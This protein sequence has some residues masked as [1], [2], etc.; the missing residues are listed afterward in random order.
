MPI[1]ILFLLV[2]SILINFAQDD[3]KTKESFLEAES[4]FLYEEYTE[5]LPVYLKLLKANPENDNLN[6]KIGVCYLNIPYEKDNAI[7][8]LEKAVKNINPSYKTNS[9]KETSAPLEALFYL[10]TAYRVNNELDKA[11]KVYKE[12]KNKVDPAVYDEDLINDQIKAIDRAKTS[13]K[14]PVF[15]EKKNLGDIVNSRFSESN[16]V[17]TFDEKVL[18][19]SVKLQFYDALFVSRKDENGE[20]GAPVNIIPELGVDGDVYPTSLSSNGN[21]MFIYRS[22]GFDGNIYETE[23]VTDKW[24]PIKK[25]NDNIN[26]KYWESHAS[27]SA[28]GKTLYFTSNRKGGYGG[29][30]IY[31][32]TRTEKYDWANV[33]NMGPEI[34][35]SYNEET[36]FITEDG[37]TLYF[38]SYGHATIGGY[39]VFYSTLQPTGE[40]SS[41][42]NMGFPINTTD[43]DIF[44]EPAQNGNFAYVTRYFP[45]NYGKNDIYRLE[46][47][48]DQHP[49]KFKLKGVIQF[50]R[51]P[52]VQSDL[53]LIMAK[54]VNLKTKD[55]I[56]RFTINPL[57]KKFLSS[58]T[59]GDYKIILE[60]EGFK[61]WV[62]EF[63]VN[64]NQPSW[65]VNLTAEML[66]SMQIA[67]PKP[68][69]AKM[70]TPLPILFNRSFFKINVGEPANIV[71]P[72][73]KGS[74]ISIQIYHDNMIVKTEDT[75][76]S[77]N[78][79]SYQFVPLEG[80]TRLV[81]K[82]T[83]LSGA[84]SIGE[85][86]IMALPVAENKMSDEQL[87][88][89][90][91]LKAAMAL[92]A[93][94]E[95]QT[96]L[97]TLDLQK[98]K[99]SSIE[100][101]MLYLKNLSQSHNYS[102]AS[103]DSLYNIIKNDQSAKAKLLLSA[104]SEI[105]DTTLLS[106]LT[107]LA[108]DTTV[109]STREI[110]RRAFINLQGN[111][112]GQIELLMLTGRLAYLG[113]VFYYKKG[114]V[115]VSEGNLRSFYDTL[116]LK[117]QNI[118][119][120]DRLLEYS[121]DESQL[122][123]FTED[124]ALKSFF[125]LPPYANNPKLLL[126]DLIALANGEL[127]SFLQSV[128]LSKLGIQT[129]NEL[130]NYLYNSARKG[131]INKEE[132]IQLII[133]ASEKYYLNNLLAK[134]QLYSSGKLH[135]FLS[136]LNLKKNN[137]NNIFDLINYLISHSNKDTYSLEELASTFARI[138]SENLDKIKQ[139][140]QITPSSPINND[141][142]WLLPSIISLILLIIMAIMIRKLFT[143]E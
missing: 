42:L 125:A 111:T 123:G 112:A 96:L 26:T 43:D 65:D 55:T 74:K 51:L 40:W 2:T 22:D 97:N 48:S 127:K 4:Y 16:A 69:S 10:A 1:I 85:I 81:F 88:A 75:I 41:P 58:I 76:A 6:Y 129:G 19:Y 115:G 36:P 37:K 139:G 130:I 15:L 44:Y 92:M 101:L 27:I 34:N 47:F 56:E 100:E 54:L 117:N 71:F 119:S 60:G 126:D 128:N 45:N 94:G 61:R 64:K 68:E 62:K 91:E 107:S 134:M 53:P 52:Q 102:S 30:D 82:V 113:D 89:L 31:T 72:V 50:D 143:K 63:S 38:S 109:I 121:L 95:L 59:A 5:A 73:E 80:K 7:D 142:P 28:N 87:A 79:F 8:Y 84:I 29:L 103:I 90:N 20:W 133:H 78:K 25:L 106:T 124:D 23:Y 3:N 93:T 14:N 137:I 12:F 39:D 122:N 105:S 131:L 35:T 110:T 57:D 67:N 120:A 141:K 32:A 104:L 21:E 99:I 98:E 108:S 9:I 118:E 83:S 70:V 116:H 24:T 136:E 49:R 13:E 17:V 138:A 86:L 114:L 140:Q 11:L 135:D 66:S 46:I 77:T 18:A 33:T 132:L